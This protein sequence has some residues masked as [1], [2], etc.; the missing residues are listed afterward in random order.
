MELVSS[1]TNKFKKKKKK[2]KKNGG[3]APLG[4]KRAQAAPF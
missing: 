3:R 2:K 1:I 4:S